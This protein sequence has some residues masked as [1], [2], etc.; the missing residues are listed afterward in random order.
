MV[1]VAMVVMVSHLV[2]ARGCRFHHPQH[3][4]AA[5]AKESQAKDDSQGERGEVENRRVVAG[6]SSLERLDVLVGGHQ[7]EEQ[8][9][10]ADDQPGQRH[11]GIR[12]AGQVGATSSAVGRSDVVEDGTDSTVDS[13]EVDYAS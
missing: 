4:T 7:D 13:G 10:A 6:W 2:A 12:G 5:G 9:Q 1:V 11:G 3:V 8:G